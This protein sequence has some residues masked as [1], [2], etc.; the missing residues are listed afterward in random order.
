LSNQNIKNTVA[1]IIQ[2]KLTLF[3]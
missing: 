2:R 3:P 1:K